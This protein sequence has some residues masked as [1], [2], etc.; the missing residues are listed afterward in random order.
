MLL[1]DKV[2][3]VTGGGYGIGKAI[4]LAFAKEG[5]DVV[6]AA[7]TESALQ[8][9]A[10]K[11]DS[12]GRKNLVIIC[13]IFKPEQ[14]ESMVTEVLRKFG[15]IDIL[16]N[17]SGIEGPTKTVAE[18]D[19]K[20]W[21]E[22]LAVNLNGAMLCSRN[23]LVKSMIPRKCGVIINISSNAGRKGRAQ[24]SP[25]SASKFALIGLTQTMAIEAGKYGI[26]VN[27]ISPGAVEGER[28]ERVFRTEAEKHGITYEDIVARS[29]SLAALGR[30]VKPEEVADL[31]VFLASGKSSGITGQTINIDAGTYFS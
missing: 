30:T 15:Q 5:A 14:I 18:M 26:R 20:G 11:I 27:A 21:N 8:E 7:R 12:M 17:N 24:R 25:Y 28:L 19:L 22:T 1:K 3:I 23:V 10:K 9:V 31:A 4:A 13:D 2:A 29:N 16:V 6:V